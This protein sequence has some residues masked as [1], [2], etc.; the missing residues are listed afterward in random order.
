MKTKQFKTNIMCGDCIAKVTPVLNE[1]FGE[2]NWEVN[3]KDPKKIL[4][5]SSEKAD[6]KTVQNVL[7]KAGYK[8]EE[9][10]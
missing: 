10:V 2:H 4:S 9:L 7:A 1:T 5:V 6:E 8:A 3:I